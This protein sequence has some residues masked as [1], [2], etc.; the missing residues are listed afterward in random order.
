MAESARSRPS[1]S[2]SRVA[3]AASTPTRPPSAP[4]AS[5][6]NKRKKVVSR[7]ADSSSGSS[8]EGS[9][10]SRTSNAA[11]TDHPPMTRKATRAS[12]G[13]WEAS[14]RKTTPALASGSPLVPR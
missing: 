13:S 9:S 6:A 10:S 12:T 14:M 7:R 2:N 3:E 1:R 11:A 4:R 8:A 5:S